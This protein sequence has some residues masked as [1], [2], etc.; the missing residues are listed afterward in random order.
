MTHIPIFCLSKATKPM[1]RCRNNVHREVFKLHQWESVKELQWFC[2]RLDF[3]YITD[4]RKLLFEGLTK[5]QNAVLQICYAMSTHAR[6]FVQLCYK[7]IIYRVR[8]IK[9]IP[10]RVLLISQQR[11]RIFIRKFTWLFLIHIYI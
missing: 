8:Q 5:S 10:C 7:Y 11:I 9:V 2:E 4:K 6:E 1:N 3:K